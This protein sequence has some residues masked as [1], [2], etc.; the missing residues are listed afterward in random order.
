MA[1]SR[2]GTN[3]RKW[4][5]GS[6]AEAGWQIRWK[7]IPQ[8]LTRPTEGESPVVT[9]QV[10]GDGVRQKWGQEVM[11]K[12]MQASTETP[13][14][15]WIRAPGLMS[16]SVGVQAPRWGL[17]G[18]LRAICYCVQGHYYPLAVLHLEQ[19]KMITEAVPYWT[20]FQIPH[21]RCSN[22]SN[23]QS[24]KFSCIFNPTLYIWSETGARQY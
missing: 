11:S 3:C 14:W 6:A 22:H 13:R 16:R 15:I 10:Q 9:R 7:A 18:P 1:G 21:Y 8:V 23:E 17:S 2:A 24:C 20:F 19:T 5:P 12:R 4:Q